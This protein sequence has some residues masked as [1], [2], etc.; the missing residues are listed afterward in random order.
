MATAER[1]QK[2]KGVLLQCFTASGGTKEVTLP[3][4]P[5]DLSHDKLIEILDLPWGSVI[6]PERG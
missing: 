2:A 5:S 1:A 4:P 6:G 3:L